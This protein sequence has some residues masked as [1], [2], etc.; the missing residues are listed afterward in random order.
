MRVDRCRST[1]PLAPVHPRGLCHGEMSTAKR[2]DTAAEI[3]R[4]GLG[5]TPGAGRAALFG[6][7]ARGSVLNAAGA[8]SS[9]CGHMTLV[10]NRRAGPDQR[11][12][13]G[14]PST[15]SALAT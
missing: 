10:A 15:Q 1:F 9:Q 3:G 14:Q 6:A 5:T 7:G 4:I 12:A 13:A 2:R 11:G 8:A